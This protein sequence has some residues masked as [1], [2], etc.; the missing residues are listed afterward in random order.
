MVIQTAIELAR[1][2]AVGGLNTLFGFGVY[3]LL[4]WLRL[5]AEVALVAATVLGAG[6]NFFS[7]HRLHFTKSTDPK[8]VNFIV[9]YTVI[10]AVNIVLLKVLQ[11]WIGS[12][13][14]SDIDRRFK[15]IAAQ[16]MVLVVLVPA[17][18]YLLKTRV[19]H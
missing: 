5:P 1:F 2:L 8:I 4:V 11:A 13:A 9:V 7:Y 17:S 16:A 12:L 14:L 10:L 6:F 15:D 3:S 19:Y 18:Y